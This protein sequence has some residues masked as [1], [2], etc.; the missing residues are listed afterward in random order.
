[1]NLAELGRRTYLSRHK[2]RRPK[3]NVFV[4]LLNGNEGRKASSTVLKKIT[5]LV[6][7]LL[8]RNVTNVYL[9]KDEGHKL[10]R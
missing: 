6:D 8:T 5:G 3:K 4:V 7:G 10:P 1:M 2:L 9:M